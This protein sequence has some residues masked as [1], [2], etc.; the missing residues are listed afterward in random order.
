MLN[1]VEDIFLE[2]MSIL[3]MYIKTKGKHSAELY[4]TSDFYRLISSLLSRARYH[5][6]D[7]P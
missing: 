5:P 2:G 7:L 1:G 3:M 4:P 6:A